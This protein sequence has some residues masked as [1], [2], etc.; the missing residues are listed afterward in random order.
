MYKIEL[1]VDPIYAVI[2][3][4]IRTMGSR[5][6]FTHSGDSAIWLVKKVIQ[7]WVEIKKDPGPYHS[8]MDPDSI[9]RKDIAA[10]KNK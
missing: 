6:D 2:F 10:D 5:L 3:G 9:S 1:L 4:S 8:Y 7:L